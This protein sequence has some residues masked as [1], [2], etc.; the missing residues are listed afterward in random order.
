MGNTEAILQ[1]CMDNNADDLR[2][3]LEKDAHAVLRAKQKNGDTAL[4]VA[5]T[6]QSME[7]VMLLLGTP[8]LDVN[9]R[10][11]EKRTPLMHAVYTKDDLVTKVLSVD[12]CDVTLL[13]ENGKTALHHAASH[14]SSVALLLE[15]GA[16]PNAKDKRGYTPLHI[17][18]VNKAARSLE[19]LLE[20][21]ARV[22]EEVVTGSIRQTALNMVD[23][24]FVRDEKCIKVLRDNGGIAKDETRY[25]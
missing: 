24:V 18:S 15:R 21:G 12:G 10:G 20:K 4:H 23:N 8:G 25:P 2:S 1:A 17:A 3:L 6:A 11:F 16:D 13:D 7:C 5:L 19:L 22:N 14:P 9:V